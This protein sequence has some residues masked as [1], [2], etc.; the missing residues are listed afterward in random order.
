MPNLFGGLVIPLWDVATITL[1]DGF[2]YMLSFCKEPPAPAFSRAFLVFLRFFL[3]F[4]GSALAPCF[5]F[6]LVASLPPLGGFSV[7]P[8]LAVGFSFSCCPLASSIFSLRLGKQ[9]CRKPGCNEPGPCRPSI[10]AV[11]P[12]PSP[13]GSRRGDGSDGRP[14]G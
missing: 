13:A 1:S 11:A 2:A 5:R 8:V 12:D 4:R 6:G 10:C 3:G 14:A 9:H 7:R